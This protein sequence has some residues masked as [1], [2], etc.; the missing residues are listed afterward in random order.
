M[1]IVVWD[2]VGNSCGSESGLVVSRSKVQSRAASHTLLNIQEEQDVM[3]P[4]FSKNE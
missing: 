2:A 1:G 4:P 3:V